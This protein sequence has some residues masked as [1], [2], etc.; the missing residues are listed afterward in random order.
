MQLNK[1][2]R[3]HMSQ[4]IYDQFFALGSIDANGIQH[5]NDWIDVHCEVHG[6]EYLLWVENPTNSWH[7]FTVLCEKCGEK[8]IT[9]ADIRLAA[10]FAKYVPDMKIRARALATP[11]RSSFQ[12]DP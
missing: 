2:L 10:D 9:H 1:V 8:L 11:H 12:K 5:M 6:R 3:P 4:P 7:P